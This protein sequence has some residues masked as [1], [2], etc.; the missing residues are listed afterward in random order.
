MDQRRFVLLDRDGT[1]I[2]DKNYLADPEG[3]ELIDGAG[4]GLLRLAGLGL[5]LVVVT[6]Q[7]GIG[8]GYFTV[9][10][11]EEVHRRLSHELEQ[12]G[13]E[14][15]GI[16]WCPHGPEDGCVCRKPRIGLIE[17]AATDLQFDPAR[18][19]VVGD[20]PRD[21][22]MG[23]AIGATTI[24]LREGR[25]AGTEPDEQDPADHVVRDLRKAAQLIERLLDH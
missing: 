4:E 2:V 20:L 17:R 24:L 15:D 1:I 14:L 18:S 6:N 7:S 19:F 11:L 9:A 22:Q 5:G 3:V 23:K 10:D 25:G 13:V 12:R 21:I 8:R 16:Y